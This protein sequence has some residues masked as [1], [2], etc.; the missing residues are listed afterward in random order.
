MKT[1]WNRL[2]A[3]SLMPRCLL[4]ASSLRVLAGCVILYQYVINYAQR[5]YL[6][7]PD[8]VLGF[9]DF[10]AVGGSTGQF[11]L[12]HLSTSIVWFEVLYHLGIAVA[13]AWVLG[14]RTRL[15]SPVNY[16]LW[17]SM[18]NRFPHL[19]DGGDNL[20][21]IV[22]LYALFADVGTHFS[23]GLPCARRNTACPG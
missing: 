22:L 16:L 10:L 13:M 12:Y 18:H 6:F 17:R 15:L 7:G 19:W 3:T 1:L 8:G 4:G 2:L 21:A 9:S 23:F 5:R 14:W 11:S 20:M